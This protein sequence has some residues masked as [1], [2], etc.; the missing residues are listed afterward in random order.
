[1]SGTTVRR[2]WTEPVM[3][4]QVS[5]VAVGDRSEDAGVTAAVRHALAELHELDA[6][7]STFRPDSAVSR[8]RAG[9]LDLAEADPR[10]REVAR[11]CRAAELATGDRFSPEW[12]GGFDPTGYV[13]GWAVDRVMGRHLAP[14]LRGDSLVGIAINLGG[15]LLARTVARAAWRWRIGIAHPDCAGDLLATLEVSN[16]AVATSGT[17]ERGAHIIDPRSGAPATQV[18][19]ATIVA[20]RLAVADVWATASVVAGTD[21][22]WLG[23]APIHSGLLLD[24][25]GETHQLVAGIELSPVGDDATPLLTR[26]P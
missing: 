26:L 9:T 4:T 18:R 11:A 2:T 6:L 3:G 8:I 13:K 7:F 22:S 23:R 24:A 15:D 20:D 5:I 17:A 14:L 1:M 25:D 16:G 10:V 21:R 19:S 12:R